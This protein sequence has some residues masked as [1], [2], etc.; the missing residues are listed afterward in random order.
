MQEGSGSGWQQLVEG[1]LV[2]Y[3]DT[4]EE[5]TTMMS[6]T[7]RVRRHALVFGHSLVF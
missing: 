3:I 7:L 2:E 6:M 1:G 4:T 5:E